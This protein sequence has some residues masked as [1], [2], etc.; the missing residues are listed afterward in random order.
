M[1]IARLKEWLPQALVGR[2]FAALLIMVA[3]QTLALPPLQAAGAKQ[4]ITDRGITIAVEKALIQEQGVSPNNVDV[5]T[6]QGIVTLSGS[7]N[8]LLAKARAVKIAESIRGVLG[9]IDLTTVTPVTRPDEDIRK[10]VL[11]ALM[12]DPATESYQVAVSVHNAVATLTGSVHSGAEAHLATEIAKGVKGLKE[13]HNDI[14]INFLAKSTDTEIA[15]DVKARLQ[16]D[17]WING[18]A[19]EVQR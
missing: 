6:S 13:V 1:K 18:A 14:T 8:D 10:D 12:Q 17:L 3:T 4:T 2:C 19:V 16:W 5:S 9:V 11:M 7:V 15:D